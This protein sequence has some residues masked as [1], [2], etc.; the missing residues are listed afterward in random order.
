MAEHQEHLWRN[1]LRTY[2]FSQSHEGYEVIL[3]VSLVCKLFVGILQENF[4][5]ELCSLE[6]LDIQQLPVSCSPWKQVF[7][8]ITGTHNGTGE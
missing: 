2:L 1:I 3:Q 8:R 7:A 6:G 5:K 4:F